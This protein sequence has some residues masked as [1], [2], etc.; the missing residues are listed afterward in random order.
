MKAVN[1]ESI[2]RDGEFLDGLIRQAENFDIDHIGEIQRLAGLPPVE[3]DKERKPAAERLGIR[4]VTLDKEVSRSRPNDVS[5]ES[6][7]AVLFPEIEP[8]P[9]PVNGVELLDCLADSARRYLMLPDYADTVLP[10]WAVFTYAVDVVDV[11]PILAI[12]SPE[13]RCGKTT[14]LSWLSRLIAK[15]LP[16]GSITAPALFRTVE[17]WKPT[18]LIDEA[19]TFLKNSDELRGIINSGHTRTSAF[20]IRTSGDDHEPRCFST[21]G[22]KVIALIG[23]LRDTLAD[24]SIHVEMRRKL[25]SDQIEHMRDAGEHFE[26]LRRQVIKW[27]D[28]NS[29][30]IRN[31]RPELPIGLNDR[32][33]DN[34]APLLA[35]ADCAGGEWPIKARQAA[36]AFSSGD[37]SSVSI[38]LL[39]GIKVVFDRVNEDHILT[40]DL[41]EAL[42]LDEEAPWS[43]WNNGKRI[44]ARQLAKKL[45]SF[46]ITTNQT[47][48]TATGRG[49][50]YKAEQFTDAFSRYLSVTRGQVNAGAGFSQIAIGDSQNNVTDGKSLKP[51]LDAGCHLVTDTDSVILEQEEF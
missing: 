12:T 41:I 46:G 8:W 15:S 3:Y 28:D 5:T 45:K 42:C 17:K 31:A 36:I 13:K 30:N 47:V 1:A 20:V 2:K 33:A 44:T 6:G 26:I 22:A 34:W 23:S 10:L 27:V 43:T 37:D 18:L 25:P 29:E 21:W 50:G 24:R 9:A 38:E 39:T 49:K 35:I 4:A 32:A 48:R 40:N 16:T 14:V 7:H 19:D 11:A 51:K